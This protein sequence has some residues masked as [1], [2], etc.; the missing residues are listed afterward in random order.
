MTYVSIFQQLNQALRTEAP[1][2]PELGAGA[3]ELTGAVPLPL[4]LEPLPVVGEPVP[5]PT[6][7]VAVPALLYP[8]VATIW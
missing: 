3:L 5:V 7:T 4:G 2:L 1:P 8:S 6:V